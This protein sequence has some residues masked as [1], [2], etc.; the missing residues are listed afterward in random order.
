MYVA[1]PVSINLLK[2][3]GKINENHDV[4]LNLWDLHNSIKGSD[5]NKTQLHIIKM[6]NKEVKAKVIVNRKIRTDWI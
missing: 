1:I 2:Q 4:K 5:L 3:E 6:D